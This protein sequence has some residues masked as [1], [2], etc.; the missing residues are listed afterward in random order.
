MMLHRIEY[1]LPIIKSGMTPT[2]TPMPLT[3]FRADP[4]PS[5]GVI[6]PIVVAFQPGKRRSSSKTKSE[7]N[8]FYRYL[9]PC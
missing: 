3:N 5:I 6:T 1:H 7:K 2:I 4:I 8:A 9:W